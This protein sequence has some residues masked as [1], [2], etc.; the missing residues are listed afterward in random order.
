[1]SNGRMPSLSEIPKIITGSP[2]GL[3]VAF[4][5]LALIFITRGLWS[6]LIKIFI[7]LPFNLQTPDKILA[8]DICNPDKM[9][10]VQLGEGMLNFLQHEWFVWV[11]LI[12]GLALFL[13]FKW[14]KK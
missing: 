3:F 6:C 10:R 11:L 2:M 9:F 1:M 5:I 12:G 13:Y 8:G 14:R 7:R 4:I